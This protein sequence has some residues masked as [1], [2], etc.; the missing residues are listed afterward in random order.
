MVL[1]NVQMKDK[2]LSQLCNGKLL[3]DIH[4]LSNKRYVGSLCNVVVDLVALM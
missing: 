2:Q 1:A 3:F 4:G